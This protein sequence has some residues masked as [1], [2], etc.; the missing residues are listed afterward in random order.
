MIIEMHISNIH[1]RDELRRHSKL[2]SAAKALIAGLGRYG[3]IVAMQAAL[4]RLEK[5]PEAF[6]AAMRMAPR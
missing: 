1:A 6:P 3:Y 2:S 4:R 5:L